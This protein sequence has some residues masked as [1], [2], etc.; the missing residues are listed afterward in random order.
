MDWSRS[1][2]ALAYVSFLSMFFSAILC[3]CFCKTTKHL[4]CEMDNFVEVV[5]ASCML[6]FDLSF[7]LCGCLY[8]VCLCA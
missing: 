6:Y 1:R 2:R 8:C 7:F 4:G 3:V 5:F